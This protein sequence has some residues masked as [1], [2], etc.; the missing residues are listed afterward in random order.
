MILR[1]SRLNRRFHAFASDATSPAAGSLP[2]RRHVMNHEGG[3]QSRKSRH[4]KREGLA[5]SRGGIGAEA[6]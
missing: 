1:V 3:R 6:S 2:F 5:G 4:R